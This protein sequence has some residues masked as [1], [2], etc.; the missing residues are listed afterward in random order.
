MPKFTSICGAGV[1]RRQWRWCVPTRSLWWPSSRCCFTTPSA[2]G[3]SPPSGPTRCRVGANV[4]TAT[5]PT[6]TSPWP[7]TPTQ[8]LMSMETIQVGG[9]GRELLLLGV[10]ILLVMF[11][12]WGSVHDRTRLCYRVWFWF[13][14]SFCLRY[15]R[16]RCWVWRDDIFQERVVSGSCMYFDVRL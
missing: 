6:S 11:R 15:V 14:L 16:V 3:R 1:A 13:P 5:P 9:E 12:F 4:G 7:A 10:Q 8:I 2:S